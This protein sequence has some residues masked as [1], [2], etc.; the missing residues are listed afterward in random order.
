MIGKFE[1]GDTLAV[2]V[3]LAAEQ[4]AYEFSPIAVLPAKDYL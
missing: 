1:V 3:I 2:C 4:Q